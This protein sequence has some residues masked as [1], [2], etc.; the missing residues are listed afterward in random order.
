VSLQRRAGGHV[1][2]HL[3]LDL[4]SK[5]SIFSTTTAAAGS[6][7]DSTIARG[8]RQQQRRRLRRAA[9]VQQRAQHARSNT[10]RQR[11]P[12]GAAVGAPTWRR[13]PGMRFISKRA[14]QGV[15]TKAIASDSSMPRLALIGIGL[16]YGP[17]SPLTKAIGSS[18]AITVSVARMVGPPTSSTARGMISRSGLPGLELLVAV[19]VL[20]HHD[21]VVDQDADGEDQREQRHAVEREAPGPAGEQRGR[22]R[23]DH[24]AADDHRLAPAQ[25]ENTSSHHR[26]GGEGQ[27]LDQLVGLVVGAWRRSCASR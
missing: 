13:M 2:H 8:C 4:L 11:R 26:R 27:L 7:T 1:D 19:D 18:A 24:R 17:I 21:G 15:T 20:H 10:A 23:Q 22:E 12:T 9:C 25:R 5:G 16:M 14:S 6:A 3:E